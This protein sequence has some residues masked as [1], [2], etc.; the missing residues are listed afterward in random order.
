[1]GSLL[2]SLEASEDAAPCSFLSKRVWVDFSVLRPFEAGVKLA[3]V[4]NYKKCYN[5]ILGDSLKMSREKLLQCV[6]VNEKAV[7]SESI[8]IILFSPI[9]ELHRFIFVIN[10]KRVK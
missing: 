8:V 7:H 5:K 3:S 4:K 6:C 9:F 1:M 10:K 2:I